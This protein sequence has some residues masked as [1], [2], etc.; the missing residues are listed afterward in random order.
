MNNIIDLHR[1][2]KGST[3]EIKGEI[4]YEN[5]PKQA[6]YGN[7]LNQ[8]I[9][10]QDDLQDRMS[11][12]GV[13]VNVASIE[14]GFQ[15]GEKVLVKG[16]VDK[17]PD[18][19]QP[20]NQDGTYPMKTS[21][22]AE[23]IERFVEPADFP[24]ASVSGLASDMPS[25][26]DEEDLKAIN[27]PKTNYTD[28]KA[29]EKAMWAKKDL[30]VAKQSACKTCGKWISDGKIEL[31][32]Y[33]GWCNRLVDYFYNED[34]KFAVITEANLM[35]SGL[36]TVT[37]AQALSWITKHVKGTDIEQDLCGILHVKE[38]DKQTLDELLQTVEK[39]SLAI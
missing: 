32:D 2:P 6:R 24:P 35:I 26:M 14:D 19:S 12:V 21:L 23:Y 30:I 36:V 1:T 37:K 20:L 4:V 5:P 9:V 39:L 8:F 33:F 11:A 10:V 29:E 15:K 13:N 17:Y 3:C 28:T 7:G 34:E 25:V 38:L 27:T 16:K 18:K 31:K 22:K